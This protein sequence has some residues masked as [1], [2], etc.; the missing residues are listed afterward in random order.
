MD[1]PEAACKVIVRPEIRLGKQFSFSKSRNGQSGIKFK[2]GVEEFSRNLNFS[3]ISKDAN[4]KMP[5][6]TAGF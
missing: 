3:C 2:I 1:L 5:C 4:S 6:A